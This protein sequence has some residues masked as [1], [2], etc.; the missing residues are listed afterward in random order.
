MWEVPFGNRLAEAAVAGIAIGVVACGSAT[1]A[2][3]TRPPTVTPTPAA[4]GAP[5]AC[6]PVTVAQDGNVGP[7]VCPDGRPSAAAISFFAR[8][9]SRLLK[10][11]PDATAA[12]V[13]NAAC[14]DL[15]A[16]PPNAGTIPLV[17]T[18]AELAFAENSW[19]FG[20]L[21]PGQ[22]NQQLVSGACVPG[23]ASGG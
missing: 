15:D 21:S 11:G 17:T 12:Q 13:V 20:D 4:L 3:G 22:I 14:D 23:A 6:G 1:P 2:V 5:E 9:P 19:S 16:P 7:V 8:I 10:L 18:E